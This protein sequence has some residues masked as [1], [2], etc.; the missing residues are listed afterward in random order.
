MVYDKNVISIDG[1]GTQTTILLANFASKIAYIK[2]GKG[3]SLNLY[4]REGIKRLKKYIKT[5]IDYSSLSIDN[6]SSLVLGIAGISNP[7]YKT[8]LKTLLSDLIPLAS[9]YL[10]SDAE[11]AHRAIWGRSHGISL[12]VGTGSIAIGENS[13]GALSRS[14]GYG[15]Q[16]GDVGS[17]YWLGKTL[18]TQL[19]IA[20]RSLDKDIIDLRKILLNHYKVKLFEEV[21]EKASSGK[22]MSQIAGLAIPLL[23]AAK[24]GN[25]IAKHIVDSGIE[26]LEDLID[27]LIK[28]IDCPKVIGLHGSLITKSEF[29]RT[30]LL[31]KLDFQ[32]WKETQV[33]VV[34]GGLRLIDER[35]KIKQ[36]K[37]FHLKYG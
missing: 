25:I 23:Q 18:L 33:E 16:I 37:A 24:D 29:Y 36:L 11:M 1:G 7:K 27:D 15:F 26:G 32:S 12:L 19:I 22:N 8:E 31:N 28:K 4:G 2:K 5:I 9:L 14:G 34:F 10:I 21:L 30:L 20:E 17:G 35:L 13:N 6:I 3:T